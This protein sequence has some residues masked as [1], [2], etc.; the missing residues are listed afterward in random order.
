M[1]EGNT[2]RS[3]VLL[4]SNG[5]HLEIKLKQIKIKLASPVNRILT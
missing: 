1:V 4:L 2:L 5:T 3:S